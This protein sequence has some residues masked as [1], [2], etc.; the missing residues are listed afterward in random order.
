MYLLGEHEAKS[1]V[2]LGGVAEG[3]L[4]HGFASGGAAYIVSKPAVRKIVD[5]GSKFPN[6]CSRDGLSE[7]V[8]VA[9]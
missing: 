2:Y 3:Y 5:E 7:D 9:R 6:D 1:Q 4:P 8:N